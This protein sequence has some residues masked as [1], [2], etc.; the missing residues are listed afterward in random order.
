MSDRGIYKP[1]PSG[2]WYTPPDVIDPA[3]AALGGFDLDPCTHPSNPTAARLH[4][5]IRDSAWKHDWSAELV[6]LARATEAAS[7]RVWMNPPF[8]RGIA[9]WLDALH[10]TIGEVQRLHGLPVHALV[11]VP[12][13]TETAWYRD[14]AWA[15][16]Q[17]V[18]ELAGRLRF[19]RR[20]AGRFVPGQT[21]RWGC[22][23]LYYGPEYARV[24][25]AL[26]GLGHWIRSTSYAG[27]R[28]AAATDPR[29][30]V[31]VFPHGRNDARRRRS[32]R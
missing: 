7:V 32:R 5:S 20:K 30:V 3:R 31:L 23:L 27:P 2:A 15:H 26:D 9:R 6:E 28:P 22:A 14:A 16:A 25:R 1:H 12:A 21:A 8:G 4:Y 17:G 13:R 10:Q 19:A 11:L 18:C 24:R 29:Q